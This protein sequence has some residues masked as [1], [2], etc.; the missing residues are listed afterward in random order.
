[1][2]DT[3]VHTL[4]FFFFHSFCLVQTQLLLSSLPANN[5]Q[6]KEEMRWYQLISFSCGIKVLWFWGKWFGPEVRKRC[7]TVYALARS[8]VSGFFNVCIEAVVNYQWSHKTLVSLLSLSL[9]RLILS[10]AL[11]LLYLQQQVFAYEEHFISTVIKGLRK[12]QGEENTPR[13]QG[14]I[15]NNNRI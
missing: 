7:E 13:I 14:N 15:S 2:V 12:M 4:I 1:M 10:L 3:L 8:F 5:L 11:T 9:P 6:N